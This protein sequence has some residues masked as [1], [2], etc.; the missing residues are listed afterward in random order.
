MATEDYSL[1]QVFRG[2]LW[3]AEIVKARLAD[4][5]IVSMIRDEAFPTVTGPYLNPQS[6]VVLVN[7][8]DEQVT[9]DIL[10]EH[11]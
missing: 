4:N 5:G 10:Q 3:E 7:A 9:K 11:V 1:V 2:G 8:C 6:V